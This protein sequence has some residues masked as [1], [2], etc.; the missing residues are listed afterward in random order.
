MSQKKTFD[1]FLANRKRRVRRTEDTSSSS[2]SRPGRATESSAGAAASCSTDT[3]A[4]RS[5]IGTCPAPTKSSPPQR[6]AR[7]ARVPLVVSALALE[8]LKGMK[9]GVT[10]LRI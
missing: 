10:D 9:V 1:R 8:A 4:Q 5:D 7:A 3:A 6:P 2:L